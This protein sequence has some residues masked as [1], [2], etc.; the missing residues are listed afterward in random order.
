MTKNYSREEAQGP[1]AFFSPSLED[2]LIKVGEV[3]ARNRREIV[4]VSR[5][6]PAVVTSDCHLSAVGQQTKQSKAKQYQLSAMNIKR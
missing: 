2:N 4:S 3:G 5:A 1:A 6:A